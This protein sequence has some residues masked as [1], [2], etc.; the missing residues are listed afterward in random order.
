MPGFSVTPV[1]PFPTATDDGFPQFLQW[2][3]EGENLGGPDAETINFVGDGVSA[4]RGTGETEKVVTVEI[5]S[6]PLSLQFQDH[7]LDLGADDATTVDI[8]GLLTAERTDNTITISMPRL[9]WRDTP[10]DAVLLIDDSENG[11]SMSGTSGAQVV[12]IAG[13]TGDS[14]VDFPIGGATLVYQE[15]TADVV[16]QPVSGVLLR[17]RSALTTTL[18]GQFATATIIKR[19]ANEYILCGDLALA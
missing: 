17:V 13:D 1:G 4:T 8:E 9:T 18:A 11:L 12:M 2:Q 3:D 7:G 14:T 15:G 5:R 6:T 10:G 19:A 16:V